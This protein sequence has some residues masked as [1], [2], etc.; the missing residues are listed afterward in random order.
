MLNLRMWLTS[1]LAPLAPSVFFLFALHPSTVRVTA[2]MLALSLLFSYVPCLLLGLPLI[3]FLEWR[4]S[5]STMRL[6]ICGA[7]IGAVVFCTFGF[8]LSGL[9]DSSVDA[10]SNI[11]ESVAGALLGLSVAILF[12]AIAGMPLFARGSKQ[13]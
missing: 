4:R 13:R 2:L 1:I 6:A 11:R 3:K 9:L 5:L 10:A 12:G 7:L 8:V